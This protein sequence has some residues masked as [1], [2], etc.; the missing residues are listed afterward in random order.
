[1]ADIIEELDGKQIRFKDMGDGTFAPTVTL[2]GSPGVSTS[3]AAA[4]LT[5]VPLGTVTATTIGAATTVGSYKEALLTLNVT[6]LSG[7]S[8]TL[9][10]TIQAS[11]DGGTTWYN[12][13][14]GLFTQITAVGT[15][16][17]QVNTFGDT[18]RANCVVAG[19][20]PS[21]TFSVKAVVK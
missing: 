15:A 17:L 1:M 14:G 21:V 12:L 7:T 18:I 10:V 3:A 11:D 8:P 5:I 6:A 2:L 20:T 16:A 13:P 19:T 9:T 4:R